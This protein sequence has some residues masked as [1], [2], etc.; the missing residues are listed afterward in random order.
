MVQYLDTVS[1]EQREGLDELLHNI[2]S[3]TRQ[4][5][6]LFA[7]AADIAMPAPDRNDIPNDV[8]DVLLEQ[9]SC[10]SCSHQLYSC[11]YTT[12]AVHAC[13]GRP[14]VSMCGSVAAQRKKG[15]ELQQEA[16]TEAGIPVTL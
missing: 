14:V 11:V 5:I 8:F 7:E 13:H 10:N 15:V 16:L 1:G 9:V 2:E 12:A 4:Y 3:N 6:K